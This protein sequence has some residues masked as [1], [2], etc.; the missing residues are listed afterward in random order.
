MTPEMGA[1][2]EEQVLAWL[3]T[4]PTYYTE[5]GETSQAFKDGFTARDKLASEQAKEI[6]PFDP[7]ALPDKECGYSSLFDEPPS[8]EFVSG[9][10]WQHEKD[11]SALAA[12]KEENERLK[13]LIAPIVLARCRSLES[14]LETARQALERIRIWTT[15]DP[16]DGPE[17]RAR[18]ACVY[19]DADRTL[20]ELEGGG[21]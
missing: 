20:K 5:M 12:L 8:G 10:R 7:Y 14:D 19:S 3:A 21:K 9:A 17:L 6:A 1:E 16:A 18:A 13:T 15:T 11:Q 4:K 2:M